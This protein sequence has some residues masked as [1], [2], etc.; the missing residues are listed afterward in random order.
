MCVLE[1]TCYPRSDVIEKLQKRKYLLTD[2]YRAYEA[3]KKSSVTIVVG[4][5]T[6]GSRD[7]DIPK[8]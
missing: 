8:E 5:S 2:S 6:D 4:D 3:R 7:S 1:M